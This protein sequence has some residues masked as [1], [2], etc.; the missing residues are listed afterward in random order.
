MA[1]REIYREDLCHAN[2]FIWFVFFSEIVCY[3]V[4]FHSTK[5]QLHFP[6]PLNAI[7]NSNI[8]FIVIITAAAYLSVIIL[9][10]MKL[11]VVVTDEQVYIERKL[12]S[13]PPVAI[14][15]S[16]IASVDQQIPVGVATNNRV[17]YSV[18]GSQTVTVTNTSG[19]SIVIGTHRPDELISAIKSVM[20]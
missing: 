2:W 15:I 19:K 6:A 4:V 20:K 1:E 14:K 3:L 13:T 5:E 12:T 7:M 18:I 16:E 17:V 11:I 10:M 9:R 8:G